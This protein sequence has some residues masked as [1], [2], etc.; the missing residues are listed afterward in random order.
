MPQK[1]T[2]VSDASVD[3]TESNANGD[4]LLVGDVD[5]TGFR[6]VDAESARRENAAKMDGV[7]TVEE[8]LSRR[9]LSPAEDE[10]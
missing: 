7:E 8:M 10:E 4:S 5:E 3:E 2:P 9:A 1:T 6:W